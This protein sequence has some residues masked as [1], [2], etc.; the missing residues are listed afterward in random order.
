MKLSVQHKMFSPGFFKESLGGFRQW[1]DDVSQ[2]TYMLFFFWPLPSS[3]RADDL[4]R[5][6]R[7]LSLQLFHDSWVACQDADVL[8]ESPSVFAGIHIAE[9]LGIPYF[10]AFTMTCESN[11]SSPSLLDKKEL[12]SALSAFD[13]RDEVCAAAATIRVDV[14]LTSFFLARI[15]SA[16]PRPTRKRSW[17]RRLRVSPL[18]SQSSSSRLPTD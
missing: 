11:S 17:Y 3:Q 6:V 12:T 8:I 1:L 18:I 4:G 2:L 14:E 15:V 10:R 16:G 9:G 5:S 13:H 7:L